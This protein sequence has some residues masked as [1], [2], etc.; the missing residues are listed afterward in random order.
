[1]GLMK[2]QPRKITRAKTRKRNAFLQDNNFISVRYICR[3]R[4]DQ[5]DFL[6]M[7]SSSFASEMSFPW[8]ITSSLIVIAG[9]QGSPV[10]LYSDDLYSSRGFETISISIPSLFSRPEIISPK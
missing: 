7:I 6:L 4:G 5:E 1:M 2:R 10:F 3:Q 8:M 9:A